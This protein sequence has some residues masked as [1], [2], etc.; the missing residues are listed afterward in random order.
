MAAP[1]R[2]QSMSCCSLSEMGLPWAMP[3][4]HSVTPIVAKAQQQPQGAP[5]TCCTSHT[6][7]YIRHK[8]PWRM[9]GLR[10]TLCLH[11]AMQVVSGLHRLQ[12][13]HAGCSLGP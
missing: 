1:A 13:R 12:G 7:L 8:V 10:D 4:M 3:T 11:G 9:L 5:P 2:S 6:V